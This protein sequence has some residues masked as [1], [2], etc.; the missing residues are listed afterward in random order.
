MALLAAVSTVASRPALAQS[1]YMASNSS[2]RYSGQPSLHL[3]HDADCAAGLCQTSGLVP[4]YGCDSYAA[5]SFGCRPGECAEGICG[6]DSEHEACGAECEP[7]M[8][9][10]HVTGSAHR[11][12]AACEDG[13]CEYV[14]RLPQDYHACSGHGCDNLSP[15]EIATDDLRPTYRIG[16][17]RRRSQSNSAV[18]PL[19]MRPTTRDTAV[20]SFRPAMNSGFQPD[21]SLGQRP[22]AF[23]SPRSLREMQPHFPTNPS[24]P[25]GDGSMNESRPW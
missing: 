17:V 12:V 7:S 15:Q 5:S 25:F 13:Q 20:R 2:H 14:A 9:L 11:H 16:S 24:E 1:S 8:A 22:R 21:D 10:G 18:Q 4:S 23:H 3:D 6:P 19:T